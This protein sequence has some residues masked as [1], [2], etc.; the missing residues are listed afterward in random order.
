MYFFKPQFKMLLTRILVFFSFIAFVAEILILVWRMHEEKQ[1][2]SKSNRKGNRAKSREK[3]QNILRA[4]DTLTVI[5]QRRTE[6]CGVCTTKTLC[7]RKPTAWISW[8]PV[9]WQR[10]DSR[11]VAPLYVPLLFLFT[12][13]GRWLKPGRHS[14]QA[15]PGNSLQAEIHL[16]WGKQEQEVKG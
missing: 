6:E 9:P 10:E 3:P 1:S 11:E 12:Q 15:N 16:G 5:K 13:K 8:R 2:V 14:Q 7:P 4:T